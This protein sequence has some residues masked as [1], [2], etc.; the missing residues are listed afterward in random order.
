MHKPRRR[1]GRRKRGKR[2]VCPPVGEVGDVFQWIAM[3]D[4]CRRTT[5]LRGRRCCDP[6][7][8]CVEENRNA[9][10]LTLAR[11]AVMRGDIPPHVREGYDGSHAKPFLYANEGNPHAAPAYTLSGSGLG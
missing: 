4:H 9:I 1:R 8:A 6:R 10:R 11:A 3:V 7:R 2:R 5:C